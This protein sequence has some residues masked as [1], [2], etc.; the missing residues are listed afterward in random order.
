M[1]TNSSVSS[2][3]VQFKVHPRSTSISSASGRA[4]LP[5][6]L[7]IATSTLSTSSSGALAAT[8]QAASAGVPGQ[9]DQPGPRKPSLWQKVYKRGHKGL[10]TA[11]SECGSSFPPTP[12]VAGMDG[13]DGFG[14][15]PWEGALGPR[16][17]PGEGLAAQL[18]A[19]EEGMLTGGPNAAA[20]K[21]SLSTSS[22]RHGGG[23]R[24]KSLTTRLLGAL[25]GTRKHQ[26][27]GAGST[28]SAKGGSSNVSSAQGS[29]KPPAPRSAQGAAVHETGSSLR[30]TAPAPLTPLKTLPPAGAKKRGAAQADQQQAGDRDGPLAATLEGTAAATG[31]SQLHQQGGGASQP[32]PLSSINTDHSSLHNVHQQSA[33]TVAAAAAAAGTGT[34]AAVAG[35]SGSAVTAAVGGLGGGDVLATN[36]S[37][38]SAKAWQTQYLMSCA[39]DNAPPAPLH[40]GLEGRWRKNLDVS[41]TGAVFEELLDMP[42]LQRLARQ[43]TNL[44]DIREDGG[45]VELLWR[46][47]LNGGREIVKTELYP[48]D[49]SIV[50]VSRRDGREGKQ[51]GFVACREGVINIRSVQGDPHPALLHDRFRLS[52]H[53][54]RLKIEHRLQLLMHGV[55]PV[56]YVTIWNRMPEPGAG[57]SE[58][59]ALASGAGSSNSLATAA[60]GGEASA[61]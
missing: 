2:A 16:L 24:P 39:P 8:A 53:G 3:A 55:Q 44:L 26:K 12:R 61:P 54:N 19:A 50:E 9:Q 43:R 46:V 60:P 32:S 10:K 47:R 4:N 21:G 59:A 25:R 27:G 5:A 49:G 22:S 52:T 56:K 41:D 15:L 42:K 20:D 57:N 48:K 40:S 45:Q 30:S 6:P 58:T 34:A 13:L 35:A 23:P 36:N 18:A 31:D 17:T 28:G 14:P 37:N 38:S 51:R 1:A 33:A 11:P 7:A 29:P